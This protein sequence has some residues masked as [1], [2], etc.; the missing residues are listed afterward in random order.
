LVPRYKPRIALT[1]GV[2]TGIVIYCIDVW[3]PI[4]FDW[5]EGYC[6]STSFL[7]FLTDKENWRL[8]KKFCCWESQ[9]MPLLLDALII[10]GEMSRVADLVIHIAGHGRP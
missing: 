9:R 10:R 2:L 3:V 5:K 1:A 7:P 6:T 8:D 4:L